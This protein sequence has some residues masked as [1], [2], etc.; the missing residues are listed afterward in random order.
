[1]A[2]NAA[3]FVRA[4][5]SG[6]ATGS[7]ATPAALTIASAAAGAALYPGGQSDVSL[8]VSNPNPFIVHVG[9]FS[10]ATGQGTGGFAVDAGHAG[11]ATSTLSFTTQT[12]GAAG[13]TVPARVGATNGT[14]AVSLPNALAM[15]AGA[16]NA[17]Q[18]ATF[19]VHLSAGL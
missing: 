7:A 15:S 1:M 12:N 19:D 13:W 17:C 5:G 8:T 16:A 11:C 3:G 4:P 14:L 10:L 2:S 6:S 18:A 9:S